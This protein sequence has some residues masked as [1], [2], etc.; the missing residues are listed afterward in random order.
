MS[1]LPS[2]L[3]PPSLFNLPSLIPPFCFRIPRRLIGI[4]LVDN[5]A[6][7]FDEAAHTRQSSGP[8]DDTD[9]QLLLSEAAVDV[10]DILNG[11]AAGRIL[12]SSARML[13]AAEGDPAGA[14]DDE[15]EGG[16]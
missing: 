6:H 15:G 7:G 14:K 16:T 12:V 5:E 11:A 10:R 2:G 8:G 1:T 13:L 9:V 3:P 4:A